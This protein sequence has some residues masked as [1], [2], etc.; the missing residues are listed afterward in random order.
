[1]KITIITSNL[2]K[3]GGIQNY[4]KR[5]IT[6]LEELG[7]KVRIVELKNT[8]IFSKILLLINFFFNILFFSP[9]FIFCTNINFSPMCYFAKKIFGKKYSITVYG[10]E[11]E[12]IKSSIYRSALINA[13]RIVKLFDAAEEDVVRQLPETKDKFIRIPNSV[14]EKRFVIKEKNVDLV[15]KYK[16]ESRKVIFTICRLSSSERDNKGYAKVVEA[17][18][19]VVKEVPNSLYLLAGGGDDKKYIEKLI[20]EKGL[21]D[22]VV[23]VGRLSDEEMVDYYNLADVFV[24][25]SKNE[26]FPAI[27]LIEALACGKPVIGG[28]Q[29]GSDAFDGKY[30]IIVDPDKNEEISIAIIKILKGDVPKN[31][32]NPI[33][34]R[35]RVINEYGID[36]YKRHIRNFLEIFNQ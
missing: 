18:S 25:V 23:L 19:D 12:N 3:I 13:D 20:K 6:A 21:E 5:L 31:M 8:S 33:E 32:L 10:I 14:D 4:N 11:V 24:Y 26:G 1:M 28:N 30:G 34:L 2:N 17:I 36:S 16:L 7:E 22:S 35:N 9:D 27:V 15:N 29:R